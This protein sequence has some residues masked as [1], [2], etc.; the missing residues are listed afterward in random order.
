M[1]FFSSPGDLGLWD[2]AG[3][4]VSF[5]PLAL[6]SSRTL[7][8]PELA[9][10]AL[11][12]GRRDL[13][14]INVTANPT[15]EGV[16]RQITEAFPWDEAPHYLIRDRDRIYGSVVSLSQTLSCLAVDRESDDDRAQ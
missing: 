3:L 4:S 10:A 14:W 7:A 15:A 1:P 11:R 13:V 2:P 8:A 16:A 12:L 5:R 6:V 9:S